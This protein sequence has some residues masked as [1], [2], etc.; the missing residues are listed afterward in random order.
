M[1]LATLGGAD[2]ADSGNAGQLDLVLALEWVRDN[3]AEFGGDPSRV[4]IFGQSAAE[5]S[6]PPSWPCLPQRASSTASSP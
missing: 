5:P 4:I 6:A 3:I 1:Y 2:Y